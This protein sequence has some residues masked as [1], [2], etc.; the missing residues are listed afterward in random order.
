MS[1]ASRCA[2]AVLLTLALGLIAPS[3]AQSEAEFDE[4]IRE[5]ILSNPEVIV[6][7]IQLWQQQQQQAEAQQYQNALRRLHD[8]L[9]NT[10]DTPMLGN[11]DGDVAIIEFVDYNCGYCR[12]VFNDLM[13]LTE[14]DNQ[15]KI[16]MKEFPILGAD[17][18]V[19]SQAALAAQRQGQYAALHTALMQARGALNENRVLSIAQDIGLDV[20]QLQLDMHDPAITATL[21]RNQMLAQQLGINGTPGFI[22]GE[23]IVRGAVSV[24][25]LQQLVAAARDNDG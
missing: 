18:L 20:E 2:G 5:Y 3:V 16:L 4:R 19:A 11:P 14:S 1:Y 15:V 10:P 13:A 25:Q 21:Q 23:E 24:S 6:E 7:A 12:R 9:Y 17:S 8:E 22:I